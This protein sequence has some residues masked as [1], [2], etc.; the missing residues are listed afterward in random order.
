MP[1]SG[2]TSRSPRA[3]RAAATRGRTTERI[4][5]AVAIGTSAS[6][7][8]E[9]RGCTRSATVPSI[10]ATNGRDPMK[11]TDHS[12]MTRPS[13]SSG[14]SFWIRVVARVRVVR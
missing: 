14:T 7:P 9:A 6:R 13:W 5:Q 2:W 3:S 1:D 11:H 12:A 10:S 4:H 8:A